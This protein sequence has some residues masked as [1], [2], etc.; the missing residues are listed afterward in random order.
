MI[1]TLK[2]DQLIHVAWSGIEPENRNNWELQIQNFWFS[3]ELF[4]LAKECKIQ[5]VIAFGSQAE[6]GR[7]DYPV[8]ELSVPMPEDAYGA[9]KLLT[10][11]YLRSL[12]ESSH[13]EWYWIRIFSVF[14][15]GENTN[16]LIPSVISKL[17]KNESVHLTSCEQRYNYLYIKDFV[18]Q[19]ISIV[20]CE[21]NK[22]GIYNICSDET[23][24]LKDMLLKIAELMNVSKDLL[25]FGRIPQRPG[26]KMFISGENKKISDTFG[27]KGYKPVGLI[28]GL[29]ESIDCMKKSI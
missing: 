28:D 26:Q 11:N 5:K 15:E 16:W 29:N 19:V 2:P 6:Y 23:I 12:S 27:M 13:S 1:R 8:T 10:S 18:H 21:E 3:K 17:L 7:Y 22:S 9:A 24:V 20:T 4:D 14:G 25:K